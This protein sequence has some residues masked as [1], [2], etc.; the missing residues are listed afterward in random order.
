[1]KYKY[2]RI[3][4]KDRNWSADITHPPH[5]LQTYN[6]Q[7]QIQIKTYFIRHKYKGTYI[8]KWRV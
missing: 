2:S 7:I 8:D 5:V 3:Y 6:I 4:Q 1:M